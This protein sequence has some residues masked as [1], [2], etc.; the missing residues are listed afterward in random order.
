MTGAPLGVLL[1]VAGLACAY[2][3]WGFVSNW[4]GLQDWLLAADEGRLRL[5]GKGTS[6][7]APSRRGVRQ[8]GYGLLVLAV[9]FLVGGLSQF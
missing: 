8:L 3:G 2:L 6:V 7:R 4:R 1:T 9:A 5:Y